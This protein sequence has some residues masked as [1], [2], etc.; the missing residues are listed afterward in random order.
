MYRGSTRRATS[1]PP[2]RRPTVSATPMAPTRLSTGPPSARLRSSTGNAASGIPSASA[3]TGESSSSG[4]PATSQWAR[5]FAATSRERGAGAC[6]DL[7]QAA[8]FEVGT[9]ESVQAE[10]GGKQRGHP[11]HPRSERG[12]S[13][14]SGTGSEAEESDDDD[15]EQEWIQDLDR[16]RHAMSRSRLSMPR[17]ALPA[18]AGLT[19]RVPGAGVLRCRRRAAGACSGAPLRR[20]SPVRRAVPASAARRRRPA[21]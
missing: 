21:R 9:E 10:E 6:E 12:Q 13:M 3:R 2:R 17:K 8:V 18:G 4:R 14:L 11:Q 1:V 7:L 16:E 19:G 20:L 15:E 5:T